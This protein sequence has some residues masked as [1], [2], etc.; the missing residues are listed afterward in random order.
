MNFDPRY[1]AICDICGAIK[2]RAY[3]FYQVYNRTKPIGI[4]KTCAKSMFPEEEEDSIDPEVF[5]K[6]I[7]K[8]ASVK[9]KPLDQIKLI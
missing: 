8:T 5:L 6:T 2:R 1:H 9:P 7:K 3:D 4:C